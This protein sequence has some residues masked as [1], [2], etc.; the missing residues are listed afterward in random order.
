[1]IS[2]PFSYSLT[3]A[4]VRLRDLDALRVVI[5]GLKSS[6]MEVLDVKNELNQ[7]EL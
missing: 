1:M 5:D 4:Y 2:L 6:G 7:G 3:V